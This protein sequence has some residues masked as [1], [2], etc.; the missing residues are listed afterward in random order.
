MKTNQLLT[1]TEPALQKRDILWK[2]IME[3]LF[4]D[5]LR[6]FF[7]DAD[8]IFDIDKGFEFLDKEL[9]EITPD[10][11]V[12]HPRFVDKLIKTWYKDGTEKWLLIHIEVQGY[13]DKT[14]PARMFTYFYRICDKFHQEITSLAIFTDEDDK[15]H[16]DRYEYECFGTSLI[17]RFNTYKVKAQD[18][19]LLE[20]SSNPFA[21]VILTVLATIERKGGSREQ[22]LE[23]SLALVRRLYE[24]ELPKEKII[25][26][27][28]FIR[29]Y[30]CF[31]DSGL[32]SK[33]EK[34]VNVISKK[35][36]HM[37]IIEQVIQMEKEAKDSK[38]V[39]NLLEKTNHSIQEIA[40]LAEVS[41]DFVIELKNSLSERE[42]G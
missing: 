35:P 26:L 4:A 34:E 14:F 38:F 21:I 18:K 20:Q 41:V 11:T 17:F 28:V 8:Y 29:S 23:S 15:Y 27:L 36:E 2:G 40:E 42:N 31:E 13:A 19:V 25:R 24:R 3:D 6:F 5:F 9:H 12:R 39:K 37:G 22:L 33:F 10:S 7:T 1:A 32:L 30:A 16:P